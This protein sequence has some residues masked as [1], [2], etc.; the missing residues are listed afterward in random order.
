MNNFA[1]NALQT[2][3]LGRDSALALG[4]GYLYGTIYDG[5]TAEH[6][7]STVSGDRNGLFDV[8]AALRIGRWH[9]R[10]E[11]LQTENLWPTTNHKVAA[12]A[13]ETA[14]D[15]TTAGAPVRISGSWSEGIQGDSGSE[16]EFNRQLV[17]GIAASPRDNIQLSLEYVR[18]MGFAPLINITTVSD[19]D[20]VQN[21]LVFGLV[22]SI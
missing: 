1:V 14:W 20:V 18:S 12:Y 10:G 3:T 17:I 5:P 22:L 6:L 8:N 7:D 2:V 15:V 9:L 21:S 4:A 19:R 16:F 13:V 11:Y